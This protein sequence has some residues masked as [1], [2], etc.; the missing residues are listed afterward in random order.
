[1]KLPVLDASGKQLREI[2]V[3]DDVFGIEPNESVVHQAYV[4]SMS[5]RRAGGAST[6]RRGEVAG[7][8]AKTR[9]QKGLGRSR[10][11]SIRASHRVGGG[12]AMGPKPHSFA[13]K[14]PKTMRR[15]AI[16]SALSSRVQDGAL[17]VVDSIASAEGRTREVQVA[18]DALGVDRRALLISGEHDANLQRAA[19]NIA[20]VK[21]MP[22]AYLNVVDIVNAHRLVMTEDAVRAA[23][24]LWGGDNVKPARGRKEAS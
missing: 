2:D 6:K 23:E 24:A 15:L 16:R 13:R 22:A 20:I 11:G 5:N 12:I 18:L 3:A 21:A 4:A 14:M 9:K 17:T 19:R 10:Q 7:S 1:M 8:T